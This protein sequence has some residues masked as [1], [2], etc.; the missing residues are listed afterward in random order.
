M[1]IRN[2]GHSYTVILYVPVLW[3][4]DIL[5][6][7]QISWPVPLTYGSRFGSGSWY[8]VSGLQD[9]KKISFCFQSYLLITF[10]RLIYISFRRQKV[11]KKQKLLKFSFFFFFCCWLKDLHSGPLPDPYKV[12]KD[13]GGPKTYGSGSTT[14]VHW[15]SI[16]LTK[17]QILHLL[18][19]RPNFFVFAF[20]WASFLLCCGSGMFS[21][22]RDPD[23]HSS[24]ISDPESILPFIVATN[25]TKFYIFYFWTGTEKVLATWQRIKV[26]FT[27]KFGY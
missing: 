12:M 8:F 19:S 23:F 7:I 16:F 11:I 26:L 13:P 21:E 27:Q 5:V 2:F 6:Q 25:F 17:Y 4:R 15:I 24:R 1:L 3:I 18:V 10:W 14:R 20:L 22:I 9:A